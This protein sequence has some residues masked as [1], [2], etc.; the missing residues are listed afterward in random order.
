MN[1]SPA[2]AAGQMNAD[3]IKAAAHSGNRPERVAWFRDLGLGLFIHWSIDVQLGMVISH[4]LVGASADYTRRDR[5]SV[6]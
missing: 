3:D 6:V 2:Q 1:T 4:S 5:K